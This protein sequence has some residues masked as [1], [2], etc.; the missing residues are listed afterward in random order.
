[1]TF[2]RISIIIPTYQGGRF[3]DQ[4]LQSIV[5]QG[6]PAV[7][8]IVIDGG[9]TDNSLEIIQKH[10]NSISYWVSEPDRGQGD[11]IN[12]GFARAT[13]EIVTF[14]SSDDMYAPSALAH[15][16]AQFAQ[17]PQ[18]GAVIGAFQF[19]DEKGQIISEPVL[20]RLDSP[21][22]C[23][24]TLLNP[25]NY[26]LHQ[27]A[28]F[29]SRRALEQVGFWVRQDL[30]YVMDRELLYRVCAA[31]PLALT[32]QV[33]GLF[34]KHALSKSEHDILPFAE[35]FASLYLNA[36]DGNPAHDRLRARYAR[37]FRASGWLKLAKARP[38]AKTAFPALL[39]ALSLWPAFLL[40]YSY[41]VAWRRVLAG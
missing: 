1:M 24:L 33:Y 36:M 23:D 13:G 28:A 20:P 35:E 25:A 18:A 11:A 6:Y 29:Y 32:N 27:V 39:R 17:N 30:H 2:P 14:L 5:S 38:Q 12:K 3:L 10:E 34:R 9:S 41:W 40:Q 21:S 26:R 15:A 22:P 8:I 19:I 7:E 16:I 4:A 31:F 37:Y